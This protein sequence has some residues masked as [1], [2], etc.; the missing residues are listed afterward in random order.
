M[1]QQNDF[2]NIQSCKGTENACKTNKIMPDHKITKQCWVKLQKPCGLQNS[3]SCCGFCNVFLQVLLRLLFF[4]Y[5]YLIT[6]TSRCETRTGQYVAHLHS[7]LL[8]LLYSFGSINLFFAKGCRSYSV[9]LW[10]LDVWYVTKFCKN[11]SKACTWHLRKYSRSRFQYIQ[12]PAFISIWFLNVN[13][14]TIITQCP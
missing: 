1:F 9:L 6:E 4:Y 2:C 10:V 11:I 3:Q 14:L 7:T 12:K 5:Y 13:L 8:L